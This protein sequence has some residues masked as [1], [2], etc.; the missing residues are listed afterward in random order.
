MSHEVS[1][2]SSASGGRRVRYAMLIDLRRCVGC[3]SCSVACKSENEVPLGKFRT[4][5]KVIEK[6]RYPD[7]S[8]QFV[9]MMCN[10]CEKPICNRNC[11]VKATYVRPDGIVEINPHRCIGC[12]YCMASCPYDVR[13]INPLRKI[14][15]KCNWC[16][17]RLDAGLLP[18][19]VETCLGRALIFGDINDPDSEISQLLATNAVTTLKPGLGTEPHCFYI[20][21]DSDAM[22][23]AKGVDLNH[24][25]FHEPY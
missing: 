5:V 14:V 6:G 4:W 2:E 1:S 17:H 13:Y 11:P 23:P 10:Q 16:A 9:P 7:V 3:Q 22:D 15:R 20:G 8:R 21:A 19:C 25:H 24:I 18:A 12:M